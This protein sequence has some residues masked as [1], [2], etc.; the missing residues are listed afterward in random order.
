MLWITSTL[1]TLGLSRFKKWHYFLIL[2]LFPIVVWPIE[3]WF[4]FMYRI[5]GIPF[6][7]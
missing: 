1:L 7:P 2:L 6:G 4:F 3:A 5:L